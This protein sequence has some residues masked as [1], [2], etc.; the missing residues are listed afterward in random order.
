MR[1]DSPNRKV[2]LESVIADG[3]PHKMLY[4]MIVDEADVRPM[5]LLMLST[6]AS[7]YFDHCSDNYGGGDGESNIYIGEIPVDMGN[8][9]DP[10]DKSTAY[11]DANSAKFNGYKLEF[12]REYHVYSGDLTSEHEGLFLKCGADGIVDEPAT[13]AR[14]AVDVYGHSFSLVKGVSATESIVC[15]KGI[16][17]F[18][19]S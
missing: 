17:G 15:Y 2:C 18:D 8:N 10:F 14:T 3:K 7:G 12:D 19:D 16:D 1:Y 9:R 11:G 5:K 13:P 4:D 6:P